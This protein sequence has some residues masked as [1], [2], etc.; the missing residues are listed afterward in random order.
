MKKIAV[1]GAGGFGQEITC[2]W[3]EMLR[4]KHEDFEFVGYFDDGKVGQ[5]L[6]YGKVIGNRSDLNN[7]PE[8]LEV[9]FAI[10]NPKTIHAIVND[11]SN[12]KISFPNIIH[13][14][15]ALLSPDNFVLG[16][17]NIFSLNVIISNNVRIGNFNIFNTRVTLGH[18]VT[19][20]NFNI[21]SPNAQISGE[22]EIGNKN[23]F[24]FN[25]GIIQVKTIG[26]ENVLGVGAILLKNIGNGYTYVG[27]PATKL[28]F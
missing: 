18:D 17:G 22:V 20:G 5:E 14:G 8:P 26:N 15:I 3:L 4:Q 7:F 11:I 21:F 27:N 24:G 10:G 6:Q 23:L 12:P 13:P 28:N 25:S 9:C 19:V 16:Y 1:F 2:V